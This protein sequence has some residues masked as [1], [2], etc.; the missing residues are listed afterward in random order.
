MLVRYEDLVDAPSTLEK[1][2]GFAGVTPKLQPDFVHRVTRFDSFVN[3]GDRSFY[4]E[5]RDTA[6]KDDAE[7]LAILSG[8]RQ[9]DFSAF[10]YPQ[11]L[12]VAS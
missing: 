5:G 12:S 6:W 1:I 3:P 2:I 9:F 8:V 11:E 7:W 4:R 10:G